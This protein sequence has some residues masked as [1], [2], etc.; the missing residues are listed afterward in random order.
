[1]VKEATMEFFELVKARR[2]I[3]RF[4][5]AKKVSDE[6]INKI[7]EA[8]IW[9]P[10][11]GNTQC[12]RFFVVKDP[13]IKDELAV[14]AGHQPF[15]SDATAVIVVCADLDAVGRSYGARGR[16]TYALQDTAVAAENMLLAI[17]ELGLA[18]CW[19]GAF[20]EGRAAKILK[21]EDH[22]R[23]VAMIPVAYS[24]DRPNPPKRKSMD[25][26]IKWIR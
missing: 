7:L 12:A 21:L 11:A 17:T 10:S 24:S 13:A 2:S 22:L 8:A 5:K 3:R 20:D 1:M 15:I 9:A 26:I 23:P 6:D 16:D 25:E 4:D 19:I 14:K 18:S